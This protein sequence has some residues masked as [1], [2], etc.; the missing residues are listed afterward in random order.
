[1]AEL[2]ARR[3]IRVMTVSRLRFRFRL[4]LGLVL[5][6]EF[7]AAS[8]MVIG[9]VRRR[10]RSFFVKILR[11]LRKIQ[12]RVRIFELRNIR[13][14]DLAKT[15]TISIIVPHVNYSHR[16]DTLL[17]TIRQSNFEDFEVLVIESNSDK[18]HKERLAAI[19]ESKKDDRIRLLLNQREKPGNNRNLGI[20]QSKGVF[21]CCLD[22]DDEVLPGFFDV[23]LYRAIKFNL[24]ISGAAILVVSQENEYIQRYDELVL[25]KNLLNYNAASG[26]SMFTRKV[27]EST[28]GYLE[29]SLEEEHIHEDWYFWLRAAL[30]GFRIGNSTLPL[31]IVNAHPLSLS[32]SGRIRDEV[33]QREQ[34]L[35]KNH[36]V[37]PSYVGI[38]N[39]KQNVELAKSVLYETFGHLSKQ[40]SIRSVLVFLPF[41]DQSGVTAATLPV[42]R[43]LASNNFKVTIV[44]TE[45]LPKELVPLETEFPTY[46]LPRILGEGEWVDFI[47]YLS[48]SRQI[49]H[50]WIVG[51]AWAYKNL[52]DIK[53]SNALVFDS[54]FNVNSVHLPSSLKTSRFIDHT[55]FESSQVESEY[56]RFSEKSHT[57]VI[58]NGIAIQN[59]P[60][61]K[62]FGIN[63]NRK[64]V[65][66]FVGR[67]AQEKNPLGFVKVITQFCSSY[68]N[69]EIEA[70]IYGEGPLRKSV[71]D[72]VKESNSPIKYCGHVDDISQIW[73][74][75]DILVVPS[76]ND[77]RP[78]VILEAMSHGV[79]VVA[80]D[81]G[82]INEMVISRHNGFIVPVG[83]YEKLAEAIQELLRDKDIL[84]R[85]AKNCLSDVNE[86]HDIRKTLKSYLDIFSG[87]TKI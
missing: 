62:I 15:P 42:I 84:K 65:I 13:P 5:A 67:L 43:H 30:K 55:F 38:N 14:E 22:P 66:A 83:D 31:S 25:L 23:L 50:Y 78:N 52:A 4:L 75:V 69:L 21:I 72:E 12:K 70:R 57:S 3:Y 7:K 33:W 77:G 45:N 59:H 37:S 19:I 51:S 36:D 80:F 18:P 9:F 26:Q 6:G 60:T 73:R 61:P 85:F 11:D 29:Q 27:F 16:I 44:C 10:I 17:E 81:V 41:L 86:K 39:Q 54:I 1:M 47:H 32:R 56:K 34:I 87:K 68:P 28:G 24:D 63:D 40:K 8:K 79:P 76:L 71:E 53:P 20:R 64:S 49:S 58:P 48:A 46:E 2:S 35:I 74:E 82:A